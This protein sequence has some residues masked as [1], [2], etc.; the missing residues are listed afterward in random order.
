MKPTQRKPRQRHRDG[1]RAGWKALGFAVLAATASL[2]MAA[3]S[4]PATA[5]SVYPVHTGDKDVSTLVL[6]GQ[7]VAGDLARLQRVT[8][9]IPPGQRIVLMLD[10]PGGSIDEGIAIGRYVY[11]AKLTTV[12]IQGPGCHSS[13]AFI[14]LAGRDASEQPMRIMMKGARV[15]FHQGALSA[16]PANQTYS[17]TDI[18]AATQIG[19]D[20]VRR[21]NT[22]FQEI[23][24]D[25]EFLTMMLSAP[26]RSITLL[27]EFDALRLGIYVM[28]TA[29]QKLT[30]PADL[31]R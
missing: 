29:T 26:N 5:A 2:T 31:K 22:Y 13:C 4:T 14:F 19:Q 7:I 6:R 11:A 3:S 8:A 20:M 12:A 16:V 9:K 17:A 28:D 24:A 21:V 15:G 30:T 27:N 1:R 18:Q 23:K 25:P 10:S